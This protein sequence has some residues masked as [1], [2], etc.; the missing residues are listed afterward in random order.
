MSQLW[1]L[2]TAAV[3]AFTTFENIWIF[4][5][6]VVGW[7]VALMLLKKFFQAIMLVVLVGLMVGAARLRQRRLAEAQN[8]NAS[9]FSWVWLGEIGFQKY[10]MEVGRYVY[11]ARPVREINLPESWEL[12]VGSARYLPAA[13]WWVKFFDFTSTGRYAWWLFM[14]GYGGF[15]SL[16]SL[17]SIK[18]AKV[19]QQNW[20]GSVV[21]QKL[22]QRIYQLYPTREGSIL[23]WMLVGDRS[24]LDERLYRQFVDSGLVHI[25]VVSWGNLM[26]IFGALML[27]L[28]WLPF[29]V[30]VGVVA[31]AITFYF[32]MVWL[33]SS[34]VR[35][36]IMVML[37]I[38]SL[39][40]G[41]E[42]LTWRMLGGAWIAM[43]IF[44]PR[45]LLYDLGFL[46][47]F[48]AVSGIAIVAKAIGETL[49]SK[50]WL[51]NLAVFVLTP[52]GAFL[53]VLPVLLFFVGEANLTGVLANI[54]VLPV[55]GVVM[56]LGLLS[57]IFPVLVPI[58]MAMI[59]FILKVNN[60]ATQNWRRIQAQPGD[61]RSFGFLV[62]M[63]ASMYVFY[64]FLRTWLPKIRY[65]QLYGGS[66]GH[67]PTADESKLDFLS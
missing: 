65:Q 19:S 21:K 31:V 53:W 28:V 40:V 57:L 15:L 1:F 16:Y 25:L 24:R 45:Y 29:Y 41:K 42:F 47:S 3:A 44:N 6:V 2:F 18:K 11:L 39:I 61:W 14:K 35:A 27:L 37:L 23:A 55:V 7:V 52:V 30:R 46:L 34:V 12:V 58:V 62:L 49:K 43:L 59:D 67:Q 26:I 33:D 50:A 54:L 56:I 10:E 8:I 64:R 38:L 48:G 51:K 4:A 13:P 22:L 5:A 36:W 17:L 66:E 63:V 60:R 32:L 9:N 20:R